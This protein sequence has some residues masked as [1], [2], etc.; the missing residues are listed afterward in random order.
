MKIK[1][2]KVRKF[3]NGEFGKFFSLV[4]LGEL[5]LGD[6][7][8]SLVD[9]EMLRTGSFKHKV[10]GDLDIT[11]EMLETMVSNFDDGVLGREV[12]F[13]W[14]HKAEDASAWLRGVRVEDGVLIGTT[15]LTEEG[16]DSIEKKKYGYFSIEYSD[17]YVDPESGTSHGVTIMGGALTNRPFI[18]KLKRIEF[19]L[20]S[21]DEGIAASLF[22]LEEDKSMFKTRTPVVKRTPAKKEDEKELTYEEIQI[23][24]AETQ[25]ELKQLKES[26]DGNKE[27][28]EFITQMRDD[29]KKLQ[30]KITKLEDQ[31]VTL[32]K[33]HSESS[34]K[35]RVIGINRVCDKL[36]NDSKH[37]PVV[38]E[39]AKE[40]ML[41]DV[42]GEKIVKFAETAGEGAEKKTTTIEISVTDAVLKLLEAIPVSQ[43][44]NLGEK[45]NIG[46]DLSLSED[47][48][49]KLQDSAIKRAFSKKGL[50]LV[51]K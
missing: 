4:E 40:I 5:A 24:L 29:Q 10:Y 36:L 18:S 21:E 32:A 37:H 13:D 25:E 43:R 39:V 27:M 45:T 49:T 9:I 48:E 31:N 7:E 3:S 16:R 22:R 2:K 15:E 20:D 46:D 47:E 14:N 6:S 8:E 1:T 33:S 51:A 19:S 12:S 38:V 17:D 44:A 34:E 35:A 28:Q 41:G 42:S 26:D 50:A 11:L 30:D 23:K